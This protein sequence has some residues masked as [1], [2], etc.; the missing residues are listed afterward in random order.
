MPFMA[1]ETKNSRGG[2][3]RLRLDKEDAWD[4]IAGLRGEMEVSA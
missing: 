4:Y 3:N 2:W 1:S